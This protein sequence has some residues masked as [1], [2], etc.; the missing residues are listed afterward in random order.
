MEPGSDNPPLV[1]IVGETASGKS[2]LALKLA[3]R[4]GGEIIAA[5][6]RTLYKGMNIGTAKPSKEDIALVPHHLINVAAPDRLISA[7]EFKLLAQTAIIDIAGRQKIPFLVGGTGLYIDAVLFDFSFGPKG[8]A[9][10]R[11]R[12]QQLSVD[13]LQAELKARDIALPANARNPRHLIRQLETGGRLRQDR[14]L[15]KNTLIIGLSIEKE[16]LS[17]RITDRIEA[18]FERGLAQE[19]QEL[20]H[21]YA[22]DYAPMRTIGYQE[23]EVFDSSAGS[24]DNLKALIKQ[25]TLQYAKRQRTWFKRN[26]SIH[27]VNSEKKAVDLI[28][29]FLNK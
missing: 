20:S 25:H 29:T 24:T 15:R 22:W 26:K 3:Q 4:F 16:E 9:A 12:W 19:V 17:Q 13:A 7:A 11:H 23:F 2:A 27:W 28:T 21:K 5:D 18:M 10:V 1:V 8:E 6:S 14:Q